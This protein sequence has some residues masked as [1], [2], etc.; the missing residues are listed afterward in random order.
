[1]TQSSLGNAVI[2]EKDIDI[3][4]SRVFSDNVGWLE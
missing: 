4:Q 2:L 3:F 1:M